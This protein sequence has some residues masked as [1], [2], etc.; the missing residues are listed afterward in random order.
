MNEIKPIKLQNGVLFGNWEEVTNRPASEITKN[1]E[2]T[3]ML[4]GIL[5]FGYETKHGQGT[6]TNG[7]RYTSDAIDDFIQRYFVENKLNMRVT[8]EHSYSPEWL[9]GRII[10][11]ES[12]STGFYYVAYIPK[13]VQRYSEV[14][15]LLANKILQGFSKDGWATDYEYRYK[16]DGS[17]DY[18]LIKQMEVVRMSIVSTPANGIPF[19]RV[20]EIQNATRFQSKKGSALAA[21]FNH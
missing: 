17:F 6:N 8:I 18:M 5:V 15:E 13:N 4:N 7:E 12:N 16:Q 21:M 11:I 20:K 19:E 14:K 2:D 9:V 3:E 1:A 10:Y